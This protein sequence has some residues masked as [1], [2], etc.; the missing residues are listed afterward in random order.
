MVSPLPEEELYNVKT[1]PFEVVNLASDPGHQEALKR[2]REKLKTWQEA[3][4]DYGMQEDSQE[5]IRAFEEYGK[6][7]RAKV[8]AK[9]VKLRAE[10]LEEVN[11]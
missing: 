8:G 11:R 4:T 5:L 10:V 7:S 9:A 3:T 1:D 6:M 2:M